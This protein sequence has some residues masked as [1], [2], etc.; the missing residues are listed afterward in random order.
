[1]TSAASTRPLCGASP[2]VATTTTSSRSARVSPAR[3]AGPGA[4]GAADQ[5]ALTLVQRPARLFLLGGGVGA[6]DADELA[7][8]WSVTGRPYR[9]VQERAQGGLPIRH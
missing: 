6:D 7:Q 3:A 2:R 5:A 9:R 1:M 8:P 4:A